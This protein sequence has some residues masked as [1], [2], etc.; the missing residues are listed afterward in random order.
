MS[1]DVFE[2]SPNQTPEE[3]ASEIVDCWISVGLLKEDHRLGSY[4]SALAEDI[5]VAEKRG[6]LRAN[7]GANKS[8]PS[9]MQT[10]DSSAS[11]QEAIDVYG[12]GRRA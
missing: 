2:R 4:R 8:A 5:R 12:I 6:E 7:A 3:H 11:S 9:V 1:E 10:P